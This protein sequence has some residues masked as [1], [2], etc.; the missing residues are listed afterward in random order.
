MRVLLINRNDFID[1]GADRVFLNTYD[2]L[3]DANAS[4]PSLPKGGVGEGTIKP[5]EGI[6]VDKFTRADVGLSDVNPRTLGWWAKLRLVR[7]YLYNKKVALAL[8]N[9]IK[10]FRPDVAHIHLIFGTL[11]VSVLRMLKKCGIPVV[12]TLHDYRLICPVNAMLDRHGKVCE[13][14]KGKSYYNCLTHRC[15]EGNLFFSAVIMLEAYLRKYLIRPL[16][17]VDHFIF[18]SEFARNKHIQFEPRYAAISSH[19]F[20]MAEPIIKT[21]TVR[22]DYFLYYGRL[23][24]EKGI[25]TLIAAAKKANVNLVIA[26]SGPQESELLA[27]LQKTD[28]PQPITR[29]PQPATCNISLVGFKSGTALKDL[30]A[31]CAFVVVPSE[32]YENNP[33]T[34]VEGFSYGKPVIGSDIGGIPELVSKETGFLFEMGN[35]YSLAKA[36]TKANSLSIEDYKKMSD[37]CRSFALKHFD[38]KY[39]FESLRGIYQ[40]AI[41]RA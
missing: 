6:L 9:K 28:N 39:H 37:S 18:V 1:G 19:L 14:C 7:E 41:N 38:Q 34:V 20:N 3:K 36:L 30:I 40:Q 12:M 5:G 15:S 29:N 10:D 32:W 26:G 8:D 33:M 2:L 35:I 16:K 27:Y 23:S 13:R 4:F 22:G 24:R 21:P 31:G 25:L 17:L 11:S